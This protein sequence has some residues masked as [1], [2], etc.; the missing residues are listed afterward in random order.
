MGAKL[1]PTVEKS[2]PALRGNRWER[3]GT[4]D[5]VK[6][7]ALRGR[8]DAHASREGSGEPLLI[9]RKLREILKGGL[10]TRITTSRLKGGSGAAHRSKGRPDCRTGKKR[11]KHLEGGKGKGGTSPTR[12]ATQRILGM[13]RTRDTGKL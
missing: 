10:L 7:Y 11:E 13:H 4:D 2:K 12:Q 6:T 5:G 3:K 9:A 1:L 8:G